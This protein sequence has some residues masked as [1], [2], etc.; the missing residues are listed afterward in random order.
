M[1]VKFVKGHMGPYKTH[2]EPIKLSLC[3]LNL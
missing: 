2:D 3:K 1:L